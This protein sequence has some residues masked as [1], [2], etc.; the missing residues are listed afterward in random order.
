M[1]TE[2]PGFRRVQADI[3]K[4]EG[5]SMKRAGAILAGR[6]RKLKRTAAGRKNPRLKRVLG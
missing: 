6:T 4:R 1:A 2:H 5:Y 3:G